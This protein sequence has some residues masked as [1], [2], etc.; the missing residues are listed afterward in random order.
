MGQSEF[1][2]CTEMKTSPEAG[3]VAS[4]KAQRSNKIKTENAWMERQ[5]RDGQMSVWRE[6]TDD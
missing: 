5:Q 1:V 3:G 6:M 2:E 4:V